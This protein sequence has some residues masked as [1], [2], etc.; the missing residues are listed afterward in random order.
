MHKRILGSLLLLLALSLNGLAQIG[1][2]AP[3]IEADELINT[4]LKS[5]ADLKGKLVLVEFFAHW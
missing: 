3:K 2:T 5:T 4:K 1:E